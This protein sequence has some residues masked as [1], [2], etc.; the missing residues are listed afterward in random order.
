MIACDWLSG[1]RA[2]TKKKTKSSQVKIRR[3]QCEGEGVGDLFFTAL[4]HYYLGACN[5]L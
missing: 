1:R 5:S 3:E 2:V 4:L